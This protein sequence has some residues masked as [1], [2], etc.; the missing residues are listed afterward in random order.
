MRGNNSTVISSPDYCRIHCMGAAFEIGA[1]GTRAVQPE[2]YDTILQDVLFLLSPTTPTGWRQFRWP[3][4]VS[5]NV[6]EIYTILAPS[7]IPV[8]EYL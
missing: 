4:K 6:N 3:D 2:M 7:R 1:A 8:L 5:Y